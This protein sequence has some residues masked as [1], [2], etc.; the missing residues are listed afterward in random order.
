MQDHFFNRY[1]APC[2][3]PLG[4]V[5]RTLIAAS[6]CIALLYTMTLPGW[7]QTATTTPTPLSLTATEW[8]DVLDDIDALRRATDWDVDGM[9]TRGATASCH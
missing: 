3:I 9:P 2:W 6:L 7:A 8:I 4:F 1:V 5:C